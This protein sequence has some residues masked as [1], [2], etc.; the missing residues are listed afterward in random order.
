VEALLFARADVNAFVPNC[1][2][3]GETPLILA[4]RLKNARIVKQLL[5]APNIDVHQKSMNGCSSGKDALDFAPSA[6][7]LR[8]LLV[9]AAAQVAA[10]DLR[11]AAAEADIREVRESCVA[12]EPQSVPGDW[13]GLLGLVA[14]AAAHVAPCATGVAAVCREVFQ[15]RSLEKAMSPIF[16]PKQ[17]MIPFSRLPGQSLSRGPPNT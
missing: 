2:G 1:Q 14:A 15:N 3:H 4:V 9:T 8:G 5:A 7:E 10:R 13:C 17:N 16:M 6:G 11:Q 12:F